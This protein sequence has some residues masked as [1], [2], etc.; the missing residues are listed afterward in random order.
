[1]VHAGFGHVE[2]DDVEDEGNKRDGRRETGYEGAAVRHGHLADMCEE[3]EHGGD[4]GED[5]GDD[6][7]DE[8]IGD[9]L[10]QDVGDLDAGII[11]KQGVHVC[12]GDQE[13]L[14]EQYRVA[15]APSW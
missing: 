15:S 10:D 9:P 11:S 1:M 14:N 12:Y 5:Q 7:Q 4:C 3:A 2:E 8:G 13:G 6:V